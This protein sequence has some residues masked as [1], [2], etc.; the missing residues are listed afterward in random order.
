MEAAAENQARAYLLSV[1]K[2]AIE[3]SIKVSVPGK[4]G[5]LLF[6][7]MSEAGP[8]AAEPAVAKRDP[9][10][11]SSLTRSST[12]TSAASVPPVLDFVKHE[13]G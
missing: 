3:E 5:E 11:K 7:G 10:V 6:A 13:A 12:A 4:F 2:K 8:V 1:A 9:E